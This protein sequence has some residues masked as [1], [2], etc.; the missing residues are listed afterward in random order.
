MSHPGSRTS[1]PEGPTQPAARL[2]AQTPFQRLLPGP[3][4]TVVRG[5][6]PRGQDRG[7]RSVTLPRPR[8]RWPCWLCKSRGQ[9]FLAA[10]RWEADAVPVWLH[11]L[12]GP[13]E[14]PLRLL[15]VKPLL[16]L[17]HMWDGRDQAQGSQGRRPHSES[18]PLSQCKVP[19]E[20]K[21]KSRA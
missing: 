17:P 7:L 6:C 4:R 5:V 3:R 12:Q 10:S 15:P 20:K 13:P 9:L 14:L 2:R 21:G 19:I 8:V 18:A 11:G 16:L 1:I